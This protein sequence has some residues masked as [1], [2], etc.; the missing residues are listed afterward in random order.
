MAHAAPDLVEISVNLVDVNDYVPLKSVGTLYEVGING[1]GYMLDD[2]GEQNP[3]RRF[4]PNLEPER[5]SVSDTPFSQSFERY[6]FSASDGWQT[7]AGQHF[8]DRTD[9]VST[10]YWESSGLDPFKDK[11]EISLLPAATEVLTDTYADLHTAVAG[12]DL[13]IQTADS[14]ITWT[15]DLSTFTPVAITDGVG[16]VVGKALTSDGQYWYLA[17]GNAVLRGQKTDPAAKWSTQAAEDVVFAAGRICAAV[18]ASGSTPNRFTTLTETGTE[19]KTNGHITFD[20]GQMVVLGAAVGGYFFFGVHAGATGSIW[21]WKLGLDSTGSFFVPFL[22]WELPTGLAPSTIGAAGGSVW[23]TTYRPDGASAGQS[24]L[25]R[26]I[27]DQNGALTPFY[28]AEL[29]PQGSTV[30]HSHAHGITEHDNKVL[31][32]WPDAAA[33]GL[34]AV[35]LETGGWSR[36]SQTAVPGAVTGM[37]VFH[38]EVVFCVSTAG[39]F[40]LQPTALAT[41]GTVTMSIVDGGTPLDKVFDALTVVMEP[42]GANQSLSFE[43]STDGGSS[44]SPVFKEGTTN[45]TIDQSGLTRIVLPLNL[46]AP[47]IQIRMTLNGPGTTS[48]HVTQVDVKYHQL[49]LAD[50][51][52]QLPVL[53]TD[54]PALLSGQIDPL[55]KKNYGAELARNLQILS[56]TRVL[57]QDIDYQLTQTAEV[58]EVVQTEKTGFGIMDKSTGQKNYKFVVTLTLRKA[59]A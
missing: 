44:F 53:C 58:F 35:N 41:T 42:L 3:Y 45:P 22:A 40:A 27:P 14:E 33:S 46:K 50:T 9:G 56:G 21:A 24:I 8:L 7:G 36:W 4:T 11:G 30:D 32:P 26:A 2:L 51:V 59:G 57:F 48:P 29:A 25:Y 1:V 17:T 28:V 55:S 23:V 5:L 12:D 49:G 10:A 52:V 31:F 15:N 13:Y 54:A 20:A 39:V 37:T 34:G 38:G 6:V 18:T 19:E 43:A 47:S 16:S